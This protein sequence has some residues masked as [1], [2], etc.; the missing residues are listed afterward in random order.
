V[1]SLHTVLKELED[2]TNNP[3]S[4]LNRTGAGKKKELSILTKN[5]NSVLQQLNKLLIKYKSLG[6]TRQRTWDRLKWGKENLQEIREKILTHTSSLTLFLTTLGTGSLGRIEKKLD[7]LIE[8]VRAGRKQDTVVTFALDGDD[9][10]EAD[11]HWSAL[12]NEFI[13]EGFSKLEVESHKN[14]IKAKLSELLEN[15]ILEEQPAVDENRFQN[16]LNV[17]GPKLRS[18][19]LSSRQPIVSPRSPKPKLFQA[20]VEDDDEEVEEKERETYKASQK[21]K[22]HGVPEEENFELESKDLEKRARNNREVEENMEEDNYLSEASDQTDNTV[23][24]SVAPQDSISQIGVE[25]SQVQSHVNYAAAKETDMERKRDASLGRTAKYVLDHEESD[26]DD[27]QNVSASGPARPRPS[28]QKQSRSET[29]YRRHVRGP[30]ET[31]NRRSKDVHRAQN[32]PTPYLNGSSGHSVHRAVSPADDYGRSINEDPNASFTDEED[33]PRKPASSNKRYTTLRRSKIYGDPGDGLTDDEEPLRRPS[34]RNN[35]YTTLRQPL[36]VGFSGGIIDAELYMRG[37]TRYIDR[38]GRTHII[39]STYQDRNPYDDDLLSPTPSS[40]RADPIEKSRRL[41]PPNV[42]R[43]ARSPSPRRSRHPTIR[44]QVSYS[45]TSPNPF[46]PSSLNQS[47]KQTPDVAPKNELGRDEGLYSSNLD[48][49]KRPDASS[50]VST[51]ANKTFHS[52]G[53]F[54]F[55]DPEVIFAEFLKAEEADVVEITVQQLGKD[56]A[57]DV[58]MKLSLTLE[59]LFHGCTK[60]IKALKENR[61]A[62]ADISFLEVHVKRGLLKGSKIEFSGIGDSGEVIW[63]DK[64]SEFKEVSQD[65]CRLLSPNLPQEEIQLY[66]VFD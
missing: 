45:D 21:T 26:Q 43:I 56:M 64:Q 47:T 20:T 40:R 55:S 66:T 63:E 41:T 16:G 30:S 10:D 22:S 46:A 61:Y 1:I 27:Y 59:E 12:K 32:E 9:A 49:R 52:G 7:E 3:D 19:F 28:V 33:S 54:T 35:R 23:E 13:D 8:D 42:D 15:G 57:T 11:A 39:D 24:P 14:W 38:Y 51:T 29:E 50:G 53:G 34:P 37:K 60:K 5:C 17:P 62:K 48:G 18:S 6:S 25:K 44:K 58:A 65:T 4:I 31:Q 2:E 36:N